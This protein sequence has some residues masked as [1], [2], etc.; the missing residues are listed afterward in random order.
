MSAAAARY[1]LI[2]QRAVLVAVVS[3]AVWLPR[4]LALDRFVTVDEPSWLTFSANFY[5]ALA[6]G[7]FRRTFQIAHPGVTTT[8]A[9][10]AAFLL[11][12]P[13]YADEA[14]GQVSWV[15][16]DVGSIIRADGHD[17]VEL[18]AAGRAVVVLGITVVLAMAAVA[19]MDLFG[20]W[21]A[22][23]GVLLIASD[24]F[25]IALSRLL[26]VD[27][28]ASSLML[29]SVLALLSHL[30]GSRRGRDLVIS[31]VAAGLAWLTKAP[32]FFLVPFAVGLI[33]FEVWP[34]WR[35]GHWLSPAAFRRAALLLVAW[36]A[37]SALVFVL[38]WPAMWVVP[39]RSVRAIV[40]EALGMARHGHVEA[41]QFFNGVIVRAGADL[42]WHFYPITYLWR[43]TPV[44]LI[45]LGLAAVAFARSRAKVIEP[46]H[47]RPAAV[48]VLYVVLF[49]VMITLGAKKFDRYL[50]PVYAPLDLIAG[51]GWVAAARWLRQSSH[52]LLAAGAVALTGL[53]VVGQAAMA[54]AAF[55]YYLSHY[56]PLLGGTARAPR[57]MMIGWG[58][59]LDQA[60]R[61]LN[62][63]PDSE[64]LRVVTPFWNGTFSYFFRGRI[65]DMPPLPRG[66]AGDSPPPGAD[67]CVIYI[68]QRQRGRLPR[69][70]VDYLDTL[71]P[72]MVV[73]IQG[74]E[75]A[76]VYDLRG[77]GPSPSTGEQRR[78]T[79]R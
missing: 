7:D 50:L 23:V 62:A 78:S 14:P 42:G 20:F 21:G 75:Y 33:L 48:L 9:G 6:R 11:R 1:R 55:P 59:G 38:A 58:E 64:Q 26:H 12:Y 18:L 73:R 65:V 57:V 40:H 77:A 71:K 30:Y 35:R 34:T 22:L 24:P 67:Y 76:H 36:G 56:N 29:L 8:W 43:T 31:A 52:E 49:T 79:E 69:E 16:Q 10:T 32:A 17:P 63:K 46:S 39:V 37:V 41:P 15:T 66:L 51:V 74:L 72:E 2:G 70:L 53:A 25:H 61:Y 45:G 60:A 3:L 54:A 28:M 19:A 68:N 27:G 5:H 47:R 44:T 13:G 4:G